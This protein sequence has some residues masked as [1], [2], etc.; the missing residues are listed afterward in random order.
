MPPEQPVMEQPELIISHVDPVEL[1]QLIKKVEQRTGPDAS[2]T[3]LQPRPN[4]RRPKRKRT[5]SLSDISE[6]SSR[7]NDYGRGFWEEQTAQ[8][9]ARDSQSFSVSG[10][11]AP[12][13]QLPGKVKIESLADELSN[14]MVSHYNDR[15]KDWVPLSD[16]RRICSPDAVAE[17]LKGTGNAS[18]IEGYKTYVCGKKPSD[19]KDGHS[20]YIVFAILVRMGRLDMLGGFS[21]KKIRDRHFPFTYGRDGTLQPRSLSPQGDDQP[22]FPSTDRTFMTQFYAE[23]WRFNVPIIAMADHGQPVEY[24]LHSETIMPWTSCRL[25]DEKGWH[26]DVFKIEIHPDHHHF[27]SNYP[28]IETFSSK[29]FLTRATRLNTTCLPSRRSP[30]MTRESFVERFTHSERPRLGLM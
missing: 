26:A 7:V 21:S 18:Q 27:V 1:H 25:L 22:R 2:S 30:L 20:A 29:L 11:W 3:S 28:R 10:T 8:T 15:T 14:A 24:E 6:I 9:S 12:E 16:L 4:G 19:F 5:Q 23:Q 13:T 17:E